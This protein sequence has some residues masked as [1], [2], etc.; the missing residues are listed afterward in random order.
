MS[1]NTDY[2]VVGKDP[3]SKLQKAQELEIPILSEDELLK[4]LY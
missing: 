1:K 4:I 3:G 2:L